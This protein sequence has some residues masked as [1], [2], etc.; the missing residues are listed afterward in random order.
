MAKKIELSK[1]P[2]FSRPQEKEKEV[3]REEGEDVETKLNYRRL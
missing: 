3:E 2:K 1:V